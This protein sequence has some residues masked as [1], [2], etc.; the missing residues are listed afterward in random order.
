MPGRNGVRTVRI[1]RAV[2]TYRLDPGDIQSV[3]EVF[4]DEVYR[5][6]FESRP[7]VI[8]DLGANIGLTSLYFALAFAPEL[9]IAIE[10]VP[11]NVAIARQNLAGIGASVVEAAVAGE[12]GWASFA[13]S[14][15]SNLGRISDDGDLRVRAITMPE[16]IDLC[17]EGHIDLLKIDI[18]GGE[19]PLFAGDCS[20]LDHVGSII[21]ELHP[22]IIE[23]SPVVDR[24]TAA[25]FRYIPAGSAW[26]GSMDAWIRDPPR[27]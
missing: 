1:G 6:P 24:I 11:G 15:E 9:V 2:L 17:P 16:V 13:S 8:V 18:E 22:H 14:A 4:V 20:W 23:T 25:G 5:P 27:R 7:R 12:C 26:V 19:G 21:A 3:R 10:P